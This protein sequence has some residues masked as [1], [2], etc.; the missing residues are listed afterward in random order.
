MSAIADKMVRYEGFH[1]V[2]ATV[3]LMVTCSF[4]VHGVIY[5]TG[6][7]MSTHCVYGLI[8]S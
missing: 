4:N 5:V 2:R 1:D 3:S 6:D 8:S 7:G